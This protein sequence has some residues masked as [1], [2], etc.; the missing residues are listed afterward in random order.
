[1][2]IFVNDSTN[3]DVF[4][5][6]M[7]ELSDNKHTPSYIMNRFLQLFCEGQCL[8]QEVDNEEYVGL[9]GPPQEQDTKRRYGNA[10][11]ASLES[12]VS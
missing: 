4:A 3:G 6:Y 11:P 1:M 12:I 10:L 2:F 8:F 9:V 5:Q 7:W